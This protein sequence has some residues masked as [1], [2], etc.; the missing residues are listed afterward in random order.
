MC[1]L[2]VNEGLI[3]ST[4][5]RNGV[6][7]DAYYAQG[8]APYAKL[9]LAVLVNH[10]SAS[11]SEIVAAC[12]QDHQRAVIV[13]ERTWGKGSV[14]NLIPLEGGRSALKLTTYSYWRPSGANIHRTGDAPESE[15]WGVS[16]TPGYDI[17]LEKD[18]LEKLLRFR[19]ERDIVH[20]AGSLAPQ[21]DDELFKVDPQLRRAVDY[22]T[23]AT[24]A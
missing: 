19:R 10:Y 12:L 13:G 23:A 21:Q 4:R 8:S 3:V 24:T 7:Y 22:L 15:E 1:Q 17:K 11:A 5:G 6:E 20:P 2:F 16:P 18:D 14:Q 9:P